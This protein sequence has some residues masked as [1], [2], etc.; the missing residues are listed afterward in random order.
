MYTYLVLVTLYWDMI[1]S[2]FAS[3]DCCFLGRLVVHQVH[4][5]LQVRQFLLAQLFHQ[6]HQ[7]LQVHF[8]L[9]IIW[10]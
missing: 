1:A 5:M 2:D 8:D 4:L 3:F 10:H 7:G 6:D 9:L